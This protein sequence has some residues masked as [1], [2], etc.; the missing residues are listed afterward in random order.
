MLFPV[1]PGWERRYRDLGFDYVGQDD[2]PYWADSVGY[3]F[4]RGECDAIQAAAAELH[5]MCLQAVD[6]IVAEPGLL[7]RYRLPPGF[8]DL[9]RRSWRRGDWTVCGR[10]DLACAGGAVKLL[11]Y[12]ADSPG[13]LLESAVVQ[14]SWF[15]ARGLGR[16]D[17]DQCN[18]LHEKL[19]ASWR[20][21]H[22]WKLPGGERLHLAFWDRSLEDYRTCE[23]LAD[24]ARQAGLEATLV[25]LAR[26]GTDGDALLDPEDRRITHLFMFYPLGWLFREA[27]APVLLKDRCLLLEPPWKCLLSDK[28]IL[29]I[30]WEL[31]PGH[32]LLLEATRD[33]PADPGGYMAKPYLGH[34]GA[35][36]AVGSAAQ[37]LHLA[38]AG[39]DGLVYQRRAD[40][41]VFQALEGG[42]PR[43]LVVGAWVVGGEPAGIC[44]REDTVPVMT[45][46]SP[47]VAHTCADDRP[48][49]APWPGRR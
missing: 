38:G 2:P 23:Y 3:E 26:I 33:R 19:V 37:P 39:A 32:R 8:D 9:V 34:G 31:F 22:R 36:V 28:R 27:F 45:D 6:R 1:Q 12:N 47:V 35:G 43:Y 4:T 41:P 15:E 29:E 42:P 10:F 11:E 21:F 30:L 16:E 40:L 18:L 5:R 20:G 17:K 7:A 48:A 46:R 44:C 25:P 49:T 24:T 13:L 14:W